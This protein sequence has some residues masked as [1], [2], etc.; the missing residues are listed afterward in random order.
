MQQ[1][2]HRASALLPQLR[3][4]AESPALPA[5]TYVLFT[6]SVLAKEFTF[7]ELSE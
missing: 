1:M 3:E 6:L 2:P 4:S 5:V 7:S